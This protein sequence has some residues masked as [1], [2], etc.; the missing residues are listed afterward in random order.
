MENVKLWT[1]S[2]IKRGIEIPC[3]F[4]GEIQIRDNPK[5]I[6]RCFNC[7]QEKQ[8]KDY[9]KRAPERDAL[10]RKENEELKARLSM[11]QTEQ[12]PKRS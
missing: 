3:T 10:R 4:C 1:N 11:P 7:K 8:K 2:A 5:K 12:N 6:V 9:A